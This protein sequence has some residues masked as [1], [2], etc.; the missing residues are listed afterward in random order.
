[1]KL[2]HGILI[3]TSLVAGLAVFPA[4]AAEVSQVASDHKAMIVS[5]EEKAKA[6]QAII[7]EHEQMKQDAKRRWY[8]NDKLTP[9]QLLEPMRGHCDAIVKDATKLRDDL[10]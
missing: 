1:M 2:L 6:Q 10:R 4:R 3:V 9:P 5:Y 7:D 8:V